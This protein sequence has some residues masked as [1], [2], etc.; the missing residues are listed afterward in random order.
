MYFFLE[1]GEI[2]GIVGIGEIVGIVGRDIVVEEKGRRGNIR[3]VR[4]DI[5]YRFSA[6]VASG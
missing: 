3:R 2:V 1:I 6:F 4:I 5:H